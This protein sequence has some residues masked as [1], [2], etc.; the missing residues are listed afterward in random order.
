VRA[1]RRPLR[2]ATYN[3]H[4]CIGRDRRHDPHRVASV[5]TELD[6]DVIALQEFTYPASVALDTRT[7]AVLTTLER[8][9]CALGPTRARV[10]QTVTECFGNALLTRHPIL[11]VQ[12]L[13]LSM[14]RR[15]PRGA[16]AATLDLGGGTHLHVLA[17]HLGLRLRERRFQVRQIL[18]YLARVRNELVVV[19]GD[20]N[21]WLPGRSAA[22]VL[23]ALLGRPPRPAS[24][25]VSRPLVSLDRVWVRPFSALQRIYAHA[26][27]TARTASDHLPIVADIDCGLIQP[28]T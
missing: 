14:A 18:N 21:D 24:F 26:S 4:A 7:P 28:L 9:Q 1:A 27:D 3:V 25:P 12:R 22:H 20:F 16:L 8:Y 5:I 6:A 15:E 2:V 13:D 10:R 23:D 17:A 19:L 11:D